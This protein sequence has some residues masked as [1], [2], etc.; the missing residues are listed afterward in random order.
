MIETVAV[1]IPS[2][3]RAEQLKRN[4]Q[5]LLDCDV[6]NG[7]ELCVV[8]A[9]CR[10]DNQTIDVL[11]EMKDRYS[12]LFAITREDGTTAVQGWNMARMAARWADWF[13]LGADDIVFH[14]A[15]LKEAML[16]IAQTGARVIGLNDGH[17]DL[18]DYA[19]HYMV[20]RDFLEQ[21]QDG[22]MVPKEY[23]SWWFDREICQRARDLGVYAPAW[24]A[25]AEHQHPDWNTAEMD[26]TYTEAWALHDVD[27]ETYRQRMGI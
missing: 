16:V 22:Y 21:H 24:L 15:W 5:T 25:I 3:G 26:A 17:T 4:V 10:G 13:V 6:P 11:W 20:H 8:V 27:R 7:V 2:K 12:D 18:N 1:L 14:T 23:K 19:P 9:M